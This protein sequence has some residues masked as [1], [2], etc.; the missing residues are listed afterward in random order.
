MSLLGRIK[1]Y[2]QTLSLQG[3]MTYFSC[4]T[5]DVNI[6]PHCL[7]WELHMCGRDNK[8]SQR[9]QMKGKKSYDESNRKYSFEAGSLHICKVYSRKEESVFDTVSYD[10]N[11]QSQILQESLMPCR[12]GHLYKDKVFVWQKQL[13]NCR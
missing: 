13:H 10:Y 6:L 3:S 2:K 11:E 7:M 12:T 5:L 8:T 4:L 9:K 1:S